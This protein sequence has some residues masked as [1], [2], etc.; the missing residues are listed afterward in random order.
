M[1][2]RW[3]CCL[4]LCCLLRC[5]CANDAQVD[6]VVAADDTKLMDEVVVTGEWPGPQMWKVSKGERVVWIL[7]TLQPLPKKMIWKY[8]DVEQIIT[9]SQLVIGRINVRPKVSI[10]GLLPL[11]MQFR[12][13]S[14]LPDKQT[15]KDVLPEE[16]YTRY[17]AILQQHAIHD[18][19]LEK[20]RPI[21]AS[22]R[23]YQDVIDAIDLTGK[24][25]VQETVLKLASQHNVPIKD[26]TIKVEEPREVLKDVTQIPMSAEIACF[27]DVIEGME[28]DLPFLKKRA[29]AWARGDVDA[30]RRL[31][32]TQVR[33]A[34]RDAVLSVQR[35]KDVSDHAKSSWVNA[36]TDSLEHN[37]S[38]LALSPVYD[39][40]GKDGVLDQL[41]AAGYTVEGP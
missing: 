7:G 40:I 15:L 26:M 9:E 27:T 3:G 6:N 39:M 24:N 5:A 28:V 23:L 34:C 22:G 33:S 13:A 1:N 36:I 31:V 29:S 21:I 35:V 32:T 18:S 30:L 37:K 41:R 25:D 14:K 8:Q 2:W 12:K 16:L 10:F 11:Y 19:D 17:L 38:A 20:L 4:M